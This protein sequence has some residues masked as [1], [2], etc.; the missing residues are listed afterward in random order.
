MDHGLS[1]SSVIA[2]D[3]SRVRFSI[4]RKRSWL[5]GAALAVA[6]RSN[7]VVAAAALIDAINRELSPDIYKAVTSPLGGRFRSH[8]MRV[9]VPGQP[10]LVEP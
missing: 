7:P 9:R 1:D 2:A 3:N 10:L 4:L 8:I 5:S 6:S